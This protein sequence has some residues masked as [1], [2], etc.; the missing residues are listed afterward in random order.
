MI[1]KNCPTCGKIQEYSSKEG[2]RR[3]KEENTEC[4]SCATSGEKNP[5]YK[6]EKSY[7][8]NCPACGKEL[9]YSYASGLSHAKK[10]NSLCTS[11]AKKGLGKKKE[12]F[13]KCP[14]CGKKMHYSNKR[15]LKKA[16]DNE[17]ECR[18]CISENFPSPMKHIDFEFTKEHKRKIGEEVK[19]RLGGKTWEERFGK[20]KAKRVRKKMIGELV[21]EV[22]YEEYVNN[23]DEKE[24]Y[25][26]KVRL[27]SKR[28]DLSS[29]KNHQ[30]EEYE[31]DHIFPVSKGF[32]RNVSIKAMSSIENLQYIPRKQN[33]TKSD[34][35]P[36]NIPKIIKEEL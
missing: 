29:L 6:E 24:K 23:L 5:M 31:L 36:D 30:K 21:D 34:N 16:K 33:R 35:I 27:K 28:K 1:A 18:E 20:E 2:L 17:S 25:E 13:R 8:R 15:S 11:C 9:E 14:S 12:L 19:K 7:K 10:V 32:Y 22:S 3:A 26:R 4:H